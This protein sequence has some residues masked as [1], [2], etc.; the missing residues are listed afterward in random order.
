MASS[1]TRTPPEAQ[2]APVN[3][4]IW[5]QIS[6][7]A[8]TAA[9]AVDKREKAAAVQAEEERLRDEIVKER[10][11]A[12]EL[13]D[14]ARRLRAQYADDERKLLQKREAV[15]KALTSIAAWPRGGR[16]AVED[17]EEVSE[18]AS[19]VAMEQEWL[20]AARKELN[21]VLSERDATLRR[22]GPAAALGDAE[23]ELQSLMRFPPH[24][25]DREGLRRALSDARAASADALLLRQ[26][27]SFLERAERAAAT[28]TAD[29]G[30]LGG[31][32]GKPLQRR[33]ASAPKLL[34]EQE[35]RKIADTQYLKGVSINQRKQL[36]EQE[37]VYPDLGKQ[38]KW[39]LKTE[40]VGKGDAKRR[41]NKADVTILQP[42][43]HRNDADLRQAVKQL[44]NMPMDK[45]A[46][47]K[48]KARPESAPAG[49]IM[50]EKD[51]E[52]MFHR[53]Y[54]VSVAAKKEQVKKAKEL[55]REEIRKIRHFRLPPRR[56][57]A[58]LKPEEV[59]PDDDDDDGEVVEIVCPQQLG[60]DRTLRHTLPDGRAFDLAVPEDL[61]PGQTFAAGPFP[62][63]PEERKARKRERAKAA[64]KVQAMHRGR[65]SRRKRREREAAALR[66]QKSAR[67]RL[68]GKQVGQL[69]AQ[70]AAQAR[71]EREQALAR[72]RVPKSRDGITE[73]WLT[74]VLRACGPPF[75]DELVVKKIETSALPGGADGAQLL[76]LTLTYGA[77]PQS[78][79]R[80]SVAAARREP[81]KYVVLKLHMP[82]RAVREPAL[83]GLTAA[84]CALEQA[85]KEAR[86]KADADRAEADGLAAKHKL[87]LDAN[88]VAARANAKAEK[89][90]AKTGAKPA[91]LQKV[92]DP[93]EV[94][95]R[96]ARAEEAQAAAD[97]TKQALDRAAAACRDL[98]ERGEAR[99]ERLLRYEHLFYA[100]S[101]YAESSLYADAERAGVRMAALHHVDLEGPEDDVDAADFVDKELVTGGDDDPLRSL[102]L[103]QDMSRPVPLG[104]A[105]E[106]VE[107]EPIAASP[108]VPLASLAKASACVQ[109]LGRLHGAL[110]GFAV[111]SGG[112]L[113]PLLPSPLYA[114]VLFGEPAPTDGA[115]TT[116]LAQFGAASAAARGGL[117]HAFVE[118]YAEHRDFEA[119]LGSRQARQALLAL[120]KGAAAGWVGEAQRLATR[121]DG[122]LHGEYA[123]DALLLRRGA[124]SDG[125][126]AA[127]AAATADDVCVGG[128]E[129][130]GSG[131]V[132]WDL[133]FFLTSSCRPSREDEA[134]LLAAYHAEVARTLAKADPAPLQTLDDVL[135]DG[136]P[137]LRREVDVSLLAALA[138]R[139]VAR[140]TALTPAV[141]D[142]T[143]KAGGR[144]A[145]ALKR[146][147]Q[148]ELALL[149]RCIQ[150]HAR[151]SDPS[152]PAAD[153][154]LLAPLEV[155][156]EEAFEACFG[157]APLAATAAKASLPSSYFKSRPVVPASAAAAATTARSGT[158]SGGAV[159]TGSAKPRRQGGSV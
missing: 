5:Q 132:A 71:L 96:A 102:L 54:E 139:V 57:V 155:E 86:A 114:S 64:T 152:L 28:S 87:L 24:A 124:A 113:Y 123:A 27:T 107:F 104:K 80:R 133:A 136:V 58:E 146:M 131:P 135:P 40:V 82:P 147:T 149:R 16:L 53:L 138:M 143:L 31:Q 88:A 101:A 157:A 142:A 89:L 70:R 129:Q 154:P 116:A 137:Q 120:Q 78:T 130:I 67:R 99:A 103:L 134:A 68:A 140:A 108:Q 6:S 122:V 36:R 77:P 144:G 85:R 121:T 9:V 32:R 90:A 158:T 111:E 3:S 56:K 14:R 25:V 126:A 150:L 47:A 109:A 73:K 43:V 98:T 13:A 156:E 127:A 112:E 22:L 17:D 105:G 20:A 39:L 37:E 84:G 125:A 75:N 128:F 8:S 2:S 45:K 44:Y 145:E 15:H 63:S 69:K 148:W 29:L 83:Q 33:L 72:A 117:L 4:A 62:R 95:A 18:R 30:V 66:I 60:P 141:H 59:R 100:P 61:L 34:S 23:A 48:E 10:R 7:A 21:K 81:P 55:E 106:F 153:A 115:A 119:V 91:G 19:Q 49:R 97:G 76:R 1:G 50:P 93:R 159:A 52:Q 41:V 35:I 11:E 94:E 151:E 38:R 51:R 26:A 46:L 42:I 110:W 74:N 79:A 92:T 65:L 118:R 12:A